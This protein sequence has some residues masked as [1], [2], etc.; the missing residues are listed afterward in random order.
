L[1]KKI[2]EAGEAEEAVD[3]M[4]AVDAEAAAIELV[5]MTT[6]LSGV[7]LKKAELDNNFDRVYTRFVEKMIEFELVGKSENILE[8]FG[9]SGG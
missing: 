9:E 5:E 1:N 8:I 2:G 7:L 6:K 4:G 3:A